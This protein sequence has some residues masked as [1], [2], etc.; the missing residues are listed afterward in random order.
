MQLTHLAPGAAYRFRVY[1]TGYQANDAYTAYLELGAPK[2][3][4]AAQIAQ[5]NG[6]TRDLPET[7]KTVR[8]TAKGTMRLSVPMRSNDIVLVKLEREKAQP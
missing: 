2:Q 4:G 1:R 6:R 8:S 5:L 7:D 3:L